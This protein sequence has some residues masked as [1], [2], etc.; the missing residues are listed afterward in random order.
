MRITSV[1]FKASASSLERLPP[2]TTPEIA[3]AGRSNVGKSSLINRMLSR[4]KLARTSSTPGRTRSIDF[5][6][7][8]DSIGL[9]DLP[10]YGFSKASKTVQ[11]RLIPLIESYLLSGRAQLVV[12]IVDVRRP[13]EE[14]D[15]SLWQWLGTHGVEFIVAATKA[16]KLRQSGQPAAVKQIEDMLSPIAPTSIT[17]FSSKTG[18]GKDQ[19]WSEVLSRLKH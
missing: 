17:L 7:A 19:L 14:S 13:P 2:Q 3:F 1:V 9:V 5:Y 18:L 11:A 16:D 8:N 10:G 4:K 12:S 6:I 15:L